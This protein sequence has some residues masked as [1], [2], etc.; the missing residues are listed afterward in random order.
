M[1]TLS[2]MQDALLEVLVYCQYDYTE[3]FA[4]FPVASVKSESSVYCFEQQFAQYGNYVCL[5]NV[6]HCSFLS[7]QWLNSFCRHSF[8]HNPRPAL[9]WNFGMWRL[10]AHWWLRR[11]DAVCRGL[12]VRSSGKVCLGFKWMLWLAAWKL[13][14]WRTG[15]G[16]SLGIYGFS[17]QT[18]AEVK[19][20]IITTSYSPGIGGSCSV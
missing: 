12:L 18:R 15:F 14:R 6:Q 10:R 11:H 5:T 1:I 13:R 19:C 16:H 9:V 17:S 8:C 3:S 4:R 20:P 2:R 7:R